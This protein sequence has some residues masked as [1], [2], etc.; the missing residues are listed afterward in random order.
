M[1]EL[2][3]LGAVFGKIVVKKEHSAESKAGAECPGMLGDLLGQLVGVRY[4]G[5]GEDPIRM[6]H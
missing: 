3:G 6:H 1:D 2:T 5:N 4:L